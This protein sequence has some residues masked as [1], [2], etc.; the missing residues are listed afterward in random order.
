MNLKEI[1]SGL[2]IAKQQLTNL[3]KDLEASEYLTKLPDPKDKRAV[4]VSLTP[5]GKE[6]QEN[7]WMKVYK[8]FCENMDKLNSEEQLDLKF[9]LI[10]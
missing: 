8:K 2:N 7:K 3:I 9:A 5:K 6:F 4:L 10:K 1:S